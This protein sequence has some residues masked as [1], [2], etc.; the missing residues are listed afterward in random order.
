MIRKPEVSDVSVSLPARGVWIEIVLCP[1]PLAGKLSLPARGVWIEIGDYCSK[2]K[3]IWV[4][5][6]EG[7]VD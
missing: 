2:L 7:S 6:R 3:I 4:T 5:P 1:I